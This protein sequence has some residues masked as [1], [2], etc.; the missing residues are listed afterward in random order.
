[1]FSH[2]TTTL[3]CSASIL[4]ASSVAYSATQVGVRTEPDALRVRIDF[5]YDSDCPSCQRIQSEILPLLEQNFSNRF[6][7]LRHDIGVNSNA[8]YMFQLEAQLGITNQTGLT[9]IVMDGTY[10][11]SDLKAMHGSIVPDMAALLAAKEACVTRAAPFALPPPECDL[12][13]ERLAHFTVYAVVSCGVFDGLNPCPVM[14]LSLI[15]GL[16]GL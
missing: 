1:M 11:Y 9:Y 2:T 12:I 10:A 3:L 14:T 5:F 7:V 13:T 8:L 6:Y 4:F 16:L 15:I